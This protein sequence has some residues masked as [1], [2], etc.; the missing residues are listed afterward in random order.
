MDSCH[1]SITVTLVIILSYITNV[2]S[3]VHYIVPIDDLPLCPFSSCHTL[4]EIATN[5]SLYID[6]S[7]TL[8]FQPGNH[9]LDSQLSISNAMMYE[10]LSNET[11]TTKIIC[12]PEAR[13]ILY[14][15]SVVQINGLGL[16]G[17][18][19]NSVTLVNNFTL[20]N[21]T[22]E[23]TN[24]TGSALVL[25]KIK[26]A[27][28]IEC[29]FLFN[30]RGM[31][32]P[33]TDLQIYLT[34]RYSLQTDES[35][36][37]MSVGGAILCSSSNVV[38]ELTT[39]DG[40][41][42]NYGG[43]IFAEMNSSM[44][45]QNSSF[46]RNRG[47]G[48]SSLNG[49]DNTY[50]GAIFAADSQIAIKTCSFT[51]NT[52][53]VAHYGYHSK[54][55]VMLALRSELSISG[56]TF[57][58]NRA[59]RNG[60]GGTIFLLDSNVR[61]LTDC[62]FNG[63]VAFSSGV[64]H[65]QT[66]NAT[67]SHSNFSHNTAH[68]KAGVIS[69]EHSS[70]VTVQNC[71]F[72]SNSAKTLGGVL[73][74]ISSKVKLEQSYFVDN[75][76]Q[77]VGAIMSV[78]EQGHIEA[79]NITMVNNVAN[80]FA[81]ALY[82]SSAAFTGFT[83]FDGNHG[84]LLAYNST[85][86]FRGE[87]IFRNCS[88]EA[89][90]DVVLQE[91]GAITAYFS[92]LTFQGNTSFNHNFAKY[93]GA[94]LAMESTITFGENSHAE[95]NT[96]LQHS[97]I[98]INRNTAQYTGGGL[99]LYHSTMTI[100]G[101]C[102]LSRNKAGDKGGGIH[103]ISSGIK[104][105]PPYNDINHEYTIDVAKNSA[106]LGGGIMMEALS[107]LSLF[108]SK[109]SVRLTKNVADYGAAMFVDD[110]TNFDICNSTH[111][112]VTPTSECFFRVLDAAYIRKV[113]SR[114]SKVMSITVDDN[115]AK[116]MGSTLYGG[117]LNRCMHISVDSV[118][119]AL[120]SNE[121]VADLKTDG[122][123]Y[124]QSISNIDNLDSVTSQ[125]VQVCFC[126]EG[127]P[128][129][130]L[131][132]HSIL[133]KKG[134]PFNI[135]IVAVDQVMSPS[136]S[137]I[138]S[139][140]SSTL[141]SLDMGRRAKVNA[142]CSNVSY[143]ILSPHKSESL[144]LYAD[145]PC[146]DAEPS[147][148]NV[149]VTF[150]P[151][152]CPIGF[153]RITELSCDCVCNSLIS[154][155]VM[156]C[157]AATE[158][159]VKR[160]NSWI[161]HT[162]QNNQSAFVFIQRCPFRYCKAP[163]S[164]RINLNNENGG[165]VQCSLGHKGI[166]CGS[167]DANYGIS[168]AHKRCLPCSDHWYLILLI[169]VLGAIFA[170]L[171]V[172]I[173]ILATNFTVAIG[174]INGFIFY[175]N[176]V[177]IYDSIFLPLETTSFPVIL[178]EWLNLDPGIDRC[179]IKGNDLYRHTWIRL[180][181]P[182]YIILIV[183]V[184]ILISE[185]SLRFS[186][187]IG[188]RNPIATLATLVLLIQTNALETAVVALRPAT[189][190]YITMNG[191]QQETVWLPDGKIKYLQGKHIPL[192]LVGLLIV[193]VVITYILLLFSWQWVAHIPSKLWILKWTKNQKL[194]SFIEAY[195]APYYTK[196]RYWT[197]LLLLVRVLLILISITSE[198]GDST[199]PLIS[200]IFILGFLFIVRLIYMKK[201]YKKWPVDLIE[202]ILLFNLFVLAIFTW[203]ALDDVKTQQILAYLSTIVT[204]VLLLCVIAY[205]I[206]AYVLVGLCPKLK[207]RKITAKVCHTKSVIS[208]YH[209]RTL[210]RDRYH[211]Q[212]GSIELQ[213]GDENGLHIALNPIALKP[214][215]SASSVVTSSVVGF[216]DTTAQ[217]NQKK[218]TID[219]HFETPYVMLSETDTSKT[220]V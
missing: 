135:S 199:A 154:D 74:I 62:V 189:L 134:K 90:Q 16:S 33:V 50:G 7:T 122:L 201:L 17:C 71:S 98:I 81:L 32:R 111:V 57:T 184:I 109:F 11:L 151:C 161:S 194:N 166:M 30:T 156:D 133:T 94:L 45:I 68:D 86:T 3:D 214:E 89:S 120:L 66:S 44:V 97:K 190:S 181:F 79:E 147:Q 177:D 78:F 75:S 39:F 18:G 206:Y 200:I 65:L 91:G 132:L 217:Y 24:S 5:T 157:D 103:A 138:F 179:Y 117:L 167:C 96:T 37:K 144:K 53:V 70:Y 160:S 163:S 40:N 108:A 8:I 171:G 12:K 55:T 61:T 101:D 76:V 27:N 41:E 202:V 195:Q 29:T 209:R 168:L 115:Y 216:A 15:I 128:N 162:S 42:A 193:V 204:L 124:L 198:D 9:F 164:V 119:N 215:P 212:V 114:G 58:G 205:H 187:L 100:R 69:A 102:F 152:S 145:G 92:Q 123:S 153:E 170:G 182:I 19:G 142:A 87:T 31:K 137:T 59:T 173:S 99:Y 104:L 176:I 130:T 105:E 95:Q 148:I 208:Q 72:T 220:A 143:S 85:I 28:I 82:S 1:N 14:N 54:G 131:R 34:E 2:Y 121:I 36:I 51:N 38:I 88:T 155:Y 118:Q 141:G 26:M 185:H 169:V 219:D 127:I 116:F 10:M 136:N 83:V 159:F 150:S 178:I 107:K 25:S 35:R 93:G 218:E 146:R 21:S 48:L 77:K 23:S 197:G 67:I 140:L 110:N 6:K 113:I 20:Y 207:I 139:L 46:H 210:N 172:V 13:F 4:S 192:F 129:C 106:P 84:S 180:L 49:T 149:N 196:H 203:Y 125:P 186:R 126:I 64:M 73:C 47:V 158:S 188:K 56:S 183:I 22:T 63:N 60:V 174:T 112:T 213:N 175:A 165:D 80:Q 211:E 43:A 52:L 191:S